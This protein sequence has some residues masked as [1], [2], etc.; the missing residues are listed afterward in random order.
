MISY[1]NRF[2]CDKIG[3]QF[4]VF[5]SSADRRT[6]YNEISRLME[7]NFDAENLTCRVNSTLFFWTG[8]DAADAT[9]VN[10]TIFVNAY[11]GK[12]VTWDVNLW[13]GPAS[14]DITCTT[15]R[16]SENLARERCDSTLPCA[17]CNF[18]PGDHRLALKG[19]CADELKLNG[20]FDTH[21]YVSGLRNGKTHFK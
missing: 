15:V 6:Q 9:D 13:P 2:F 16:G 11:T 7:E 19:L 18:D 14:D 10:G 1:F 5:N 4:P 3:G 8:L 20:D 12:P 17:V 21:Y